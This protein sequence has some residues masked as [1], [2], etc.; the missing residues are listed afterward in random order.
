MLMNALLQFVAD[1][2]TK[3]T[4][5][6][7]SGKSSKAPEDAKAKLKMPVIQD[8]ELKEMSDEGMCLS[9]HQ[10]WASLLVAGIKM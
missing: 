4:S 8:R 6:N 5:E 1:R 9:M 7:S 10:P 2:K 3:T